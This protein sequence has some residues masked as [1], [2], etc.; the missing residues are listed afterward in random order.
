MG[1]R[2]TSALLWGYDLDEPSFRHRML[3]LGQEL[4]A[5]GWRCT[6]ERLPKRRYLVRILER[7][8]ALA[9]ADILILHR[10]KCLSPELW[11]LRRFSRRMVY[12][13]D[14]A[15]YT[16]R[17]E[18]TL[19]TTD[20][21]RLRVRKFERTCAVADMVL[22]CNP[23][24]AR[25]AGRT[26][27]RVEIVPTPVDVDAFDRD[28]T[29]TRDPSV[30]VWIGL[31]ENLVYLE[32]VRGVLARLAAAFPGLRLRVISSHFPDWPEVPIERVG[33][34][35]EREIEGLRTAG[36]GIMPLSDDE[37]TRGKCAFKLIQYMAAGLPCVASPVGANLE[38]MEDGVTGFLAADQAA[39][40][41]AL[42]DLL[43]DP[44][45]AAA[46]GEA[47]RHRARRLYDRRVVA[48]RAADLVAGIVP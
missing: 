1:E 43:A 41:S 17:R 25:A 46:M 27:H 33:W 20:P 44:R 42:T 37:W 4:E 38:A 21:S 6:F 36:I 11:P 12:D 29:T 35:E 31:P 15:V 9:A 3:P 34:S 48:A 7:R 30:V 10:I 26:A 22:V 5:R 8:A 24:L 16:S 39:W 13:V 23:N 2:Q 14:D 40:E 47:G 18:D 28:A 32:L 45:R 19:G